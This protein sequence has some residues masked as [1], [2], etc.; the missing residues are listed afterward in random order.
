MWHWTYQVKLRGGTE[1]NEKAEQDFRKQTG[2][3]TTKQ[4]T[5]GVG[6]ENSRGTPVLGRGENWRAI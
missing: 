5:E 4:I 3:E 6:A 2:L 1:A